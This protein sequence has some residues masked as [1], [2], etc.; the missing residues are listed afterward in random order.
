V[1]FFFTPGGPRR[2]LKSLLQE[3]RIPRAER[4]RIPLLWSGER[5][6]A[7]ADL[8]VDAAVRAEAGRPRRGRLI[9]HR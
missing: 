1:L 2:L 7:A 5:L 8:W 4:A 3:A 9:W 6:L